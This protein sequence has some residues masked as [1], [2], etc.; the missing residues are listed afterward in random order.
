MKK[1][2]ILVDMDDTLEN[3]CETWV[4]YLNQRHGTSVTMEDIKQWDMTKAFPSLTNEEI[5]APTTEES[6]WE[7]VKPIPKAFDNIS[8]LRRDG[9]KVLVVTASYPMSVPIKLNKVLFK[10][11]PFFTYKDVIITSHKQLI[12]G[13]VLV[14]D[15][16]HNLVNGQYK[17]ILM[18]APHNISFDEKI[19]D[20]IRVDD[21]DEIYNIINKYANEKG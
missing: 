1:L 19:I 21:W 12:R 3:L 20:A 8:K 16:P 5:F 4:S 10:Y 7:K 2:T 6:M 9:H 15:A 14:D 17:R 18:T 13:D 11:F